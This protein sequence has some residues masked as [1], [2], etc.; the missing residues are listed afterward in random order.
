[1]KIIK[2]SVEIIHQEPGYNGMIRHIEK[3]GRTCYKSA[4]RITENSASKFVDSLKT[5][6]HLSV[7]EHGAVY[8][9]VPRNN[10][11]ETFF[12]INPYSTIKSHP[13]GNTLYISTNL[14]VIIEN[15]LEDLLQYMVECGPFHE[16]RI[17]ARFFAQIAI[18]REFNRHRVNSV[19]EEST[20][21]VNYS[22]N[23]FG[24]QIS[25]N[26]PSCIGNDKEFS[27]NFEDLCAAIKEDKLHEW[28]DISWW[29]FSNIFC[30]TSYMKLIEKGWKPQEARTVLPLD[31][32]TELIHTAF[33]NDWKHFFLLRCDKRAHPDARTLA[34]ELEKQMKELNII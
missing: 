17:T 6:G 3:C 9:E 26:A 5:L 15:E 29:W 25:L 24:N 1:M 12:T 34:L 7:L 18:S 33:I 4:D 13:D 28:D 2:P 22:K 32:N 31:T 21:Y 8:L 30:E 11:V 14:R 19:S 27:S 10:D 16:K 23:R 20:R